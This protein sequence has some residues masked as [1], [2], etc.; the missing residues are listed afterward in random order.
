MVTE[1]RLCPGC[2]EPLKR[3]GCVDVEQVGSFCRGPKRPSPLVDGR[4][5]SPLYY[6]KETRSS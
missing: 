1:E 5:P 3:H 4:A 6:M 2:G